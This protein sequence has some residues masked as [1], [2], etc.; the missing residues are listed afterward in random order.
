MK[1][2]TIQFLNNGYLELAEIVGYSELPL[3]QKVKTVKIL[4]LRNEKR[5]TLISPLFEIVYYARF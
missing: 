4:T 2:S 3:F 5:V 1:N